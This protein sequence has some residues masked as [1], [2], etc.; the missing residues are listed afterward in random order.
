MGFKFSLASVLRLRESIE[1][2]EELALQKAQYEVENVRTRIQ[3]LT[4]ELALADKQREQSLSESTEAYRLQDMQAGIQLAKEAKQRLMETL[5]A[6][7]VARD[8]QMAVYHA[9]RRNREMLSDLRVE[10]RNAWEQE[11]TRAQ[12]K[13]LD[14]LF[15]TRFQRG[16]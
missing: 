4:A 1:Q 11:Q 13:W 12:Q 2:R 9:A 8:R 10:Q 7:K 15:A 3:E 6:L 14:D 5:E 16:R